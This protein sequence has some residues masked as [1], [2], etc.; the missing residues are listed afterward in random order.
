MALMFP[1]VMLVVNVSSVA[2]LWFG[3]HRIEQRRD[4]DRRADRVPDLPDADPDVGDDGDVHVDDGPARRGLRRAHRRGA[5]HRAE[6]RAAGRARSRELAER[7]TLDVRAT[8]SFRYPGAEEPVLR[9]VSLQRAARP[10]DRDHR[11]DRRRQDHA[12]Q[13]GPAALRRDRR[14]RCWSTASTC[15][16][17][18][19]RCS[20]RAI[21]LVPQKAVPLL[22]H[23]R[24]ATCA[25][26]S[27]TPPTR[28]CGTRSR[29]RRPRTSSSAMPERARRADRAGR[30][31]RLRRPAA[32]ARDRPG[33]GAAARDLPLRRL[34]LGARPRHRRR[35]ARRAAPGDPR[36]DGA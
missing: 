4:A 25:T 26:A 27:P 32:A 20:G 13:P 12:A 1:T 23:G 16:T 8:S 30:H 29:S 19:P 9:D 11:L 15:A 21:G 31:Q 3:G 36:R 17:S 2:V 6:R 14:A 28:S 18:T 10:D 5:R 22:R 34:V 7:G 35:A 24:A 33:A